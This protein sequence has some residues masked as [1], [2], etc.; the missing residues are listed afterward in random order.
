VPWKFR[1]REWRA[2]PYLAARVSD[3]LFDGQNGKGL[4]GGE[5]DEDEELR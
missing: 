4:G 1:V 2:A 3:G 5:E